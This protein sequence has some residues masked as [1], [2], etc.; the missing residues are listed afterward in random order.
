MD[1]SHKRWSSTVLQWSGMWVSNL[2]LIGRLTNRCRRSEEF[3]IRVG[4]C[5]LSGTATF[6][7]CKLILICKP[8][9][10][11]AFQACDEQCHCCH[12]NRDRLVVAAF[13]WVIYLHWIEFTL[14]ELRCSISVKCFTY[15]E[16]NGC[17][18]AVTIVSAPHRYVKSW[19][20]CSYIKM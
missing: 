3:K 7:H 1:Y 19:L 2:H 15:G 9:Q 12:K 8:H 13:Q 6:I 17:F 4:K 20:H 14:I 16:N 11:V 18:V 5:V 10:F